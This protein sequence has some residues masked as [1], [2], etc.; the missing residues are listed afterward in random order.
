MIK[1]HNDILGKLS[2]RGI[3]AY[4]AVTLAGDATL[5]TASLAGSV[6]VASAMMREGLK[7]LE[8]MAPEAV[9]KNKKGWVC[10]LGGGE[11]P[12]RNE[13]LDRFRA[14]TDDLK[15]YWDFMNPGL[16]FPMGGR[17][18]VA[19]KQFLTD[20]PSW[21]QDMWRVALNHRKNSVM[22]FAHGSR[23]ESL[24]TWVRKLGDYFA[25]PLNA[26]NKPVEGSGKHGKVIS[27]EQQNRLARE[28]YLARQ[29]A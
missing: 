24:F 29:Q 28:Q 3:L 5:T 9:V 8:A 11:E 17:D 22:Y 25:G 23:T 26:F 12:K 20:H 1:L 18:G 15:K 14:L 13:G 4:V 27:L 6:K 10:G 2:H 16:P 19:I 21:S 7:E